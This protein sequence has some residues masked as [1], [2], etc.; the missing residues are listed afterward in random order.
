VKM[1]GGNIA[2]NIQAANDRLSKLAAE[3]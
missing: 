1:G 2:F 3:P